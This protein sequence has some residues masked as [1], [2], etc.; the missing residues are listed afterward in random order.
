M[1]LKLTIGIGEKEYSR[2][3]SYFTNPEPDTKPTEEDF[4]ELLKRIFDNLLDD[5]KI[6]PNYLKTFKKE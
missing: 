1:Y 5:I 4:K 2:N 3:V 6:D